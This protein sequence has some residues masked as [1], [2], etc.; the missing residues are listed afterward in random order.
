MSTQEE[1]IAGMPVV[2]FRDAAEWAA[3]LAENHAAS[4]GLWLRLAKKASGLASATYAEALE[5]ALCYGWIDGQK[6]SY[7]ASS[8]LQKFTPRGARSIWSKINREKAL[9]LIE[10]GRMRPA[11]LRAI[12]LARQDGRW[13]AVYDP[14]ST[15]TVPEG[16]QAAL[17]ARPVASAAFAALDGQNRYAMLFRIQTALKPQTRAAR[18][19]KFVEMLERGE[20]LYP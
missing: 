7:D 11:G 2:L 8:W 5:V 14:A 3:W 6:K 16:F 13:D 20:K 19:G 17:D 1:T 18:V 15:A 12:E 4:L 10:S 9:A